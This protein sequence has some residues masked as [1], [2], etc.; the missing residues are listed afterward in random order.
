MEIKSIEALDAV[1]SILC[2]S[3]ILNSP[4]ASISEIS[5]E[6]LYQLPELESDRF[7][8]N[9]I[10]IMYKLKKDRYVDSHLR[11]FNPKENESQTEHYF[12]TFEG[13]LFCEQDGYQGQINQRN[14]ESIRIEKINKAQIDYQRNTIVLTVILAVGT[15]ISAVYYLIEI[16]KYSLLGVNIQFLTASFLFLAGLLAGIST[17]LIAKE[18]LNRKK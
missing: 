16:T 8:S 13:I 6:V 11:P 5:N 12:I 1:L 14:A 2:K 9:L 17:L 18:V 15:A 3:P 10:R 7:Y 4:D